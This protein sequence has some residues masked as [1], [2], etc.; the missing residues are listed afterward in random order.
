MKAALAL[1]LVFAV[2]WLSDGEHRP[3]NAGLPLVSADYQ[4]CVTVR[5]GPVR[6]PKPQIAGHAPISE[7]V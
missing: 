4:Q 2:A 5:N 6:P 7:I 1:A 3:A